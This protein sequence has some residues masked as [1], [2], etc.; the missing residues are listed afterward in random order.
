MILLT[1]PTPA[2]RPAE[3]EARRR[4]IA[5]QPASARV[6]S[7]PD[8]DTSPARTRMLQDLFQ[9]SIESYQKRE[10]RHPQRL[11]GG[12]EPGSGR[13]VCGIEECEPASLLIE[14]PST[15]PGGPGISGPLRSG[16]SWRS[17]N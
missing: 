12:R 6:R 17:E 4:K 14:G 2:E 10:Q 13:G 15:A 11:P 16:A 3:E 1:A 9:M 7:E 8:C 5:R